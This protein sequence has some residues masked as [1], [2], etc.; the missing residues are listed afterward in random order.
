MSESQ[1]RYMKHK[2]LCLERCL[3]TSKLQK[4]S[5]LEPL[6]TSIETHTAA[7]AVC[8]IVE[9]NQVHCAFQKHFIHSGLSLT[10]SKS[11]EESR[12]L[13]FWCVWETAQGPQSEVSTTH[14]H[15]HTVL[16]SSIPTL[17]T[18][19]S[20]GWLMDARFRTTESLRGFFSRQNQYRTRRKKNRERKREIETALPVWAEL[21]SVSIVDRSLERS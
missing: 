8:F 19:R 13:L 20:S 16:I 3:T 1:V 9:L 18:L 12:W 17:T 5:S 11:S 14:T 6:Q 2:R 7:R 4:R 21:G 15:T 10:W